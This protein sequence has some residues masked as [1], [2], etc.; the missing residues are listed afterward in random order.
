M[1]HKVRKHFL[2]RQGSLRSAGAFPQSHQNFHWAHFQIAKN[3]K[4]LWTTKILMRMRGM[5]RLICLR[6]AHI[7]KGTFS[8]VGAYVALL[9]KIDRC[10]YFLHASP[11]RV[12]L[13]AYWTGFSTIFTSAD[14]SNPVYP[15]RWMN[16][17]EHNN[18]HSITKTYLY[19]F[20]PLKPHFYKV[21]LGFTWIYIIFLISVQKHK[22]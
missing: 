18:V 20:D 3:T 22:L 19:D 10:N 21:K 2:Y 1:S 14:K 9:L 12:T 16:K 13:L 8:P 6:L 5:C 15:I 4:F 7:S 17:K 11:I